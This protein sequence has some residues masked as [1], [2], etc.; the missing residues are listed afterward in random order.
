MSLD[1]PSDQILRRRVVPNTL[2]RRINFFKRRGTYVDNPEYI[3]SNEET[4]GGGSKW[5]IWLIVGLIAL[6]L[7]GLLIWFLLRR[8]GSST[9]PVPPFDCNT[10]GCTT[11]LCNT[12]TGNCVQC[13]GPLDCA[14]SQTCSAGVCVAASCT[15]ISDCN[16]AAGEICNIVT[17]T[18]V[19]PE[20]VTSADCDASL[21]QSCDPA[22]GTCL[23]PDCTANADCP[24]GEV[25]N[26]LGFCMVKNC[27]RNIDCDQTNQ[28]ICDGSVCIQAP[29]TCTITSDC[30]TSVG[31][32]CDVVNGFCT[33]NDYPPIPFA[34]ETETVI[35]NHKNFHV[36]LTTLPSN[37]GFGNIVRFIVSKPGTNMGT[38]Y[39]TTPYQIVLTSPQNFVFTGFSD[40]NPGQK[41]YFGEKYEFSL[42]FQNPCLLDEGRTVVIGPFS[43]TIFPQNDS[44]SLSDVNSYVV[45]NVTNTQLTLQ[46]PTNTTPIALLASKTPGFHANDFEGVAIA[47]LAVNAPL[48]THTINWADFVGQDHTTSVPLSSGETWYFLPY[49]IFGGYKQSCSLGNEF[50]VTIP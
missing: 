12:T 20:C 28:E 38:I 27:S 23:T 31:Y 35:G 15:T 17:G 10:D 16:S 29:T 25:C 33:C 1:R 48:A 26:A 49:Q 30:N 46:G 44:C 4:S 13:L 7:I 42:E 14:G 21:G 24:M 40:P 3:E 6:L 37:V 43:T 45:V 41:F 11:G 50:S 8:G 22:T 47:T 2:P 39:A 34:F 32:S 36:T 18:C 5:W 9:P 19:V